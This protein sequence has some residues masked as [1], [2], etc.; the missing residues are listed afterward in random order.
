MLNRNSILKATLYLIGEYQPPNKRK[1]VSELFPA[2]K[3][4]EYDELFDIRKRIKKQLDGITDVSI[5]KS[6]IECATDRL[7]TLNTKIK[8]HIGLLQE[9]KAGLY[10]YD[11]IAMLIVYM[12]TVVM[13]VYLLARLFKDSMKDS[14]VVVIYAGNYHIKSGYV[15]FIEDYM[16]PIRLISK[17]K[18]LSGGKSNKCVHLSQH[19]NTILSEYI[20]LH[21][22]K[23]CSGLLSGEELKRSC[24][25][26]SDNNPK[27]R[28]NFISP[29]VV[30]ISISTSLY[31]VATAVTG[32]GRA[33]IWGHPKSTSFNFHIGT[34]ITISP[35]E[36]ILP[37][38][39]IKIRVSVLGY[40]ILLEDSSVYLNIGQNL[41]NDD[42]INFKGLLNKKAIDISIGSDFYAM[43]NKDNRVFVGGN[44][45]KYR[46]HVLRDIKF[47]KLAKR[48]IVSSSV[49]I[50]STTG[51]VYISPIPNTTSENIHHRLVK[52]PEPI[53]QIS[54][55][56][57]AFG[58]LSETGKLYMWGYI[59]SQT[60]SGQ[61]EKHLNPVEISFG[62]PI[63]YVSVGQNFTIAVSNDGIVNYW[64]DPRM[65]PE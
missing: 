53:V 44:I 4:R 59:P 40:I 65:K 13:D 63:N 46:N 62:L 36:I 26:L 42:E 64:G 2:L 7:N 14:H 22:N 27:V 24:T 52:L 21:E 9:D 32:N 29:R 25:T 35:R 5:K 50:L 23:I 11:D 41:G 1:W 28:D 45:S 12:N 54:S 34:K 15:K 3:L 8:Y 56:G 48:V 30:S 18:T 39:A 57:S 37:T 49:M 33:Y 16:K 6:I 51:E 19:D 17:P 38:K 61:R 43:I 60:I 58:A 47:P 55:T 31:E 10:Y 20:N